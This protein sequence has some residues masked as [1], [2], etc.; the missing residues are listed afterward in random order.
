VLDTISDLVGKVEKRARK[1]WITQEMISKMDERRKWKNVSTEEGRKNYRRLR[2]ELKRDTDNDKKEYL[3]NI[4]NEIIEFQRTGRCDLTYVKTKDPGWKE[5]QGIQN[6]G[7]KDSRQ[8]RIVDQSQV[9]KIWDNYITELYDRPNRPETLEVELEEEVDTDEKGPYILQSEVKKAIK[10]IRNK[11]ATGDDVPG[12]VLKL[13]GE[14]GLK[15]MTKLI[16]TI[17]ETGEWPKDFTE[18]TMI[19]LKNKTQATKC[20]D[21]RTI[22]LIVHTAKIVA[23]ILRR[24]IERKIETVL[25]EDQ[26]GF[27]RGKVTRDA[28]RMLR[29]MSERTMEIDAQLYVCFIDWQKAFYRVN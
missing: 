9:P 16:N 25:E 23:K 2:K 29:I 14:C 4:C 22:S 12:D 6:I 19:A 10:E 28:I 27:R 15:I 18:V 24:R 17:Y 8:N 5:I 1:P 20:S 11:N 7:I 21:H 26:F 3:E 13:L